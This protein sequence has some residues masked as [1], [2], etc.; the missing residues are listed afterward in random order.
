MSEINAQQHSLVSISLDRCLATG[1]PR[2]PLGEEQPHLLGDY[3][4]PVHSDYVSQEEEEEE[5]GYQN[6]P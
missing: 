4:G 5:G 6:I 1:R 2:K 3:A